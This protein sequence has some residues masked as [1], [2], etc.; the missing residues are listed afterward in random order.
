[1][2]EMSSR[3]MLARSAFPSGFW[4]PP[5]PPTFSTTLPPF[6]DGLLSSSFLFSF[7]LQSRSPCIFPPFLVS[8]SL[9]L[10]LS[11]SLSLSV[12]FFYRLSSL[13]SACSFRLPISAMSRRNRPRSRP[14]I[15]PGLLGKCSRDVTRALLQ[16]HRRSP[17]A[18]FKPTASRRIQAHKGGGRSAP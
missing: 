12:F 3:I 11:L 6:A 14:L 13:P 4:L 7:P 10:P 1:M 16:A 17:S 2:P 9:S 15:T 18:R 8:L 5:P